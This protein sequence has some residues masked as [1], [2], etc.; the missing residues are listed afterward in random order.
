MTT[1]TQAVELLPQS[2][3]DLI[4]EYGMARTDGLSDPDRI[5]LW[6]MLIREIKLFAIAHAAASI[7]APTSEP[8]R[9]ASIDTWQDRMR[10]DDYAQALSVYCRA[11]IADL[12]TALASQSASV[13]DAKP[14]PIRELIAAHAELLED[15]DCCY[16][17]LAR[18][19]YTGWMAWLCANS[20]DHEDNR[21][22]IAKGQG[23]TPDEACA[24]AIAAMTKE[25][26]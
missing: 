14:D 25:P 20:I 10:R 18:T 17:E 11:E 6:E 8:A 21:K 3:I 19:R 13:E 22:I 7:E 5:H 24:A 16:F 12:R 23:S 2:L 4:G 15:N 26:T 1:Q 9:G